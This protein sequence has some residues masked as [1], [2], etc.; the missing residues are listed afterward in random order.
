VSTTGTGMLLRLSTDS[1]ASTPSSRLVAHPRAS[2]IAGLMDE[3]D[4]VRSEDPSP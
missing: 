1:G 3:I 2:V 4:V